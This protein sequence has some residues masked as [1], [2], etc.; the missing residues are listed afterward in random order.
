M[1]VRRYRE[2]KERKKAQAKHWELAGTKMGNILGIKAKE[3]EGEVNIHALNYNVD[4]YT[5]DNHHTLS[6]LQGD[7]TGDGEAGE[8][9]YKSSQQFAAHMKGGSQAVSSF[10]KYK[11]LKEQRQF[12]PIFATRQQVSDLC[13]I[14]CTYTYAI[15]HPPLCLPSLSLSLSSTSCCQ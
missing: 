15:P 14:T 8:G 3:G 6:W 2:E 9:N 4:Q 11:T 7:K 1:L 12:L 10:A 13:A 5:C